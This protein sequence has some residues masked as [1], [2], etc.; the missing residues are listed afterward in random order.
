MKFV[1]VEDHLHIVAHALLRAWIDAGDEDIL[2][3]HKV[4]ESFIPH[5]FSHIHFRGDLF[6]MN[7]RRGEIGIMDVLRADSEGDLLAVEVLIGRREGIGDMNF[8]VR[9]LL[10]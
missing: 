6:A 8:G 10:L 2:S 3:G 4:K 9:M 1:H 7:V 5:Q